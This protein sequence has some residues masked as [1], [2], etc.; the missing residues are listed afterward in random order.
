MGLFCE[1]KDLL[2]ES[3]VEQKLISP[4]LIA[5]PPKGFGYNASDF[6]TK[7]DLKLVPIGKGASDKLY[8][9]DYVIII[10]GLPLLVI[11]AKHPN[12]DIG[13]SRREARLYATE[14][15]S[16][17]PPDINPCHKII[18]TNGKRII[19]LVWDS[20][21]PVID[22]SFDDIF[23]GSRKYNDLVK[24]ASKETLSD[25]CERKYK[26]LRGDRVFFKPIRLLGGKIIQNEELEENG[27]GTNLALE[28]RHIFDPDTKEDRINIVRNAY[29]TSKRRLKHVD[30]IDKIIRSIKPPSVTYAKEIEDMS[31]PIE[32]IEQLKNHKVLKGEVILLIGSVGSG[33]STFLD[34]LK[35][36]GLSSELKE[37]LAWATINLNTA[38]ISKDYI[39]NWITDQLIRELKEFYP[40]TDFEH[41]DIILKLYSTEIR[42][43]EK[44]RLSLLDKNS[45][46]YKEL[47]VEELGN[48]QRSSK[49]T[50]KALIRYLCK[51]RGKLF[52]VTLDN[53]DKRT[54]DEQLLMFSVAKWLQN[55][56][57]CLIFLPI[58][59]TTFDHHRKE[60][61][62]D[63]V[64]KDLSFRIDPPLLMQVIYKRVNYVLSKMRS[65][66]HQSLEYE[67]S[68]GMR[69]VYPR[70]DQGK[71][72]ACILKSLFQNDNFF[73]RLITGIAGRDI[74]KGLEIFLD[75]CKS[76]H[77]STGEI[78]KIRQF[79]GNYTLPRHI[80]TRVLLRS[81]RKY[82]QDE[83][84]LI[85]NL[86]HSYP[87][88]T[89]PDPFVRIAILQWL[90]NMYRVPGPNNIMGYHK[91]KTLYSTLIP[92][93]HSEERIK[94]ELDSLI[95]AGCVVVES[96]SYEI[97]D[98]E[99]LISI[100]PAGH[101]HLDLL[102]NVD[103]LSACSED[104]WFKSKEIAERIASRISNQVGTGHLTVGT[105]IDNAS[106]LVSYLGEYLNTSI[107]DP[108]RYLDDKQCIKLLD[109]SKSA[110]SI[111][112]LRKSTEPARDEKLLIEDYPS[113]TTI[114][115]EI[116]SI[117][118]YG[119][120][121]EFGL[122]AHGFIHISHFSGNQA[123]VLL[124]EDIEIGDTVKAQIIEYSG[125]H[126][127]FNLK[128]IFQE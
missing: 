111:E 65:E 91:I 94:G 24:F 19:G 26:L 5:V 128:P 70:S 34:Y 52:I 110:S 113:G 114:E 39:Y 120:F 53:C 85:K 106:D 102:S 124:F 108:S 27:F 8:Y 60:P 97:S 25:Y 1:V 66:E 115:A 78:F 96:Q 87:E 99:E 59:D 46:K 18:V 80:V 84:S 33:K 88:D 58:R 77:I 92:F 22:L 89:M 73:R 15:N 13:M 49:S 14:L 62:L 109:F 40:G 23:V 123:K 83:N 107:F 127:K 45:A 3:D 21:Q 30:P 4:I 29:V 32:I 69:V 76:G 10:H 112:S 103:Y 75:F 93:G 37:T 90:K 104:V 9:P 105:S 118:K 16:Y 50:L 12:V 121:V 38:P 67:L 41:I 116:V 61:P 48:L 56:C 43:L 81:S 47:L 11:E 7:T 63:T 54:R 79:E 55:E 57:E 20:D 71:Y 6:R 35:D 42:A 117:Q 36:I 68:N 119:I 101:V 98:D 86:L 100:A 51:E 82:Y 72:L 74:R 64:I 126:H 31:N 28:Y 95:K 122:N 2:N 125:E 17:F 44:G